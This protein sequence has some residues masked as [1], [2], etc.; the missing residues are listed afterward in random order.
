MRSIDDV[1][2][3]IAWLFLEQLTSIQFAM[4][5]S[6]SR[7]RFEKKLNVHW[8]R[9][10]NLFICLCSLKVSVSWFYKFSNYLP[11]KFVSFL[12][13]RLIFILFHCFS[14]F[15]NFFLHIWRAYISERKRCFNVTSSTVYF[16]VKIK[17]LADFRFCINIPIRNQLD[18][19]ID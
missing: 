19:I 18:Q 4:H 8:W 16:H 7:I 5:N 14:M 2:N 3:L 12:K 10:E 11:V 13:N 17:I 15:V 6:H 1:I 9:F